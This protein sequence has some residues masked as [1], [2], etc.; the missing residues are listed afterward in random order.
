M[1]QK[2]TTDPLLVANAFL[3]HCLDLMG[4]IA[5]ILNNQV[6]ASHFLQ[7]AGEARKEFASNYITSSGRLVSDSQTAYALAICFNLV[8]SDQRSHAGAR[9][10]ELIRYNNFKVGTGFAGTPFVCEALYQT[11]H[12]DV[13]YGMTLCAECPSWLYPVTMGATTVWERW[14]SMLP[15]GS[16]NPGEMTSFNHYAYGAIAKFLVT[17][18]AGLQCLEP[19]WKRTRAEPVIEGD[20]MEAKAEHLS[21]YGK[22]SVSWRLSECGGDRF[23]LMIDVVVPP[24]T[25]MEVVLPGLQDPEIKIVESG[26]WSFTTVYKR[27]CHWPV[28]P[29]SYDMP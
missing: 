17:R 25:Q 5:L 24:T 14:D 22:V 16:I 19:G 2:A 8:A 18:L 6:D 1:P 10:A 28:S 27:R 13:A 20:F 4:Q 11:G 7:E 26:E 15:D 3:V 12:I 21:P 29:L 23:Q 9:L